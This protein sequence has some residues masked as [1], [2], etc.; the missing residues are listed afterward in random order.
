MEGGEGG[1]E[2][3]ECGMEG[4]EGGMEGEEGGMEGGE[5][6]IEEGEC[7][8]EGGERWGGGEGGMEGGEGGLEEEEGGME[9][10]RYA[11]LGAVGV[12]AVGEHSEQREPAGRGGDIAANNVPRLMMGN[13][14]ALP[15]D[16]TEGAE[17]HSTP[18]ARFRRGGRTERTPELSKKRNLPLAVGIQD[19]WLPL[20]TV[21]RPER[22]LSQSELSM[23]WARCQY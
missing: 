13:P 2:E 17:G 1:I 3:G 12:P 10:E 16:R 21:S 15:T 9:G 20:A 22:L 4:G 6:G 8:M 11:S 18:Q 23:K 19:A 14:P 5:G 7:G